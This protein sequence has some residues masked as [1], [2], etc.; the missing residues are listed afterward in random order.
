MDED[1]KK[2]WGI[3]VCAMILL[4][5]FTIILAV[6]ANT[7]IEHKPSFTEVYDN[8]DK[9]KTKEI[10]NIT[11]NLTIAD[12]RGLEGCGSC[13]F[14]KGHLPGA[15]RYTNPEALY[16]CTS[17]ILVYSVDGTKGEWFCSQ[18]L[19][20]VYGKIYNLEGGWNAWNS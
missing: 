18:L 13:Q 6:T 19:G 10:I 7:L 16:N 8:I 20:H 12:I 5:V 14:N 17:D 2:C 1:M 3:I 15:E 4:A 11:N 9:E